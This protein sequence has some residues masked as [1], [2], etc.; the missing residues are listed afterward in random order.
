MSLITED[1]SLHSTNGH[2]GFQPRDLGQEAAQANAE[3]NKI[4]QQICSRSIA[5]LISVT[6]DSNLNSNQQQHSITTEDIISPKPVITTNGKVV[7][8]TYPYWSWVPCYDCNRTRPPRCHH[9]P[10]CRTCVLKRDHHCFFAGACIGYRNHR[11]FYVFLIWAW[12]SCIYAT[13]HG[14]PYIAW[15]LWQDMSYFDV[16]FPITIMRFIL[17]YQSF[18]PALTVTTLTLLLYFDV[19]TITFIYA[20]TCLIAWGLT[21]FEKA[22]LKSS[23]ELKDTRSLQQKIQAVFGSYWALSIIIPTHFFFEP[24]ENPIDWPYVQVNKHWNLISWYIL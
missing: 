10:V 17:G 5:D 24:E 13:L 14:F 19:I 3:M 9:C 23:L 7:T 2:A 11:F 4:N 15:Y 1:S 8:K 12:L 22:Y 18:L 21:S 20:H 6:T 16:F